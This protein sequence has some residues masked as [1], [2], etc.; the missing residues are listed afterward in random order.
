MCPCCRFPFCC[1]SSAERGVTGVPCARMHASH[2]WTRRRLGNQA[3]GIMGGERLARHGEW[4][5]RAGA[6]GGRGRFLPCGARGL[7]G[8]RAG[9]AEP[10]TPP[11]PGRAPLI[12]SGGVASPSFFLLPPSLASVRARAPQVAAD[13]IPAATGVDACS[14]YIYPAMAPH[15]STTSR[16]EPSFFLNPTP[17]TNAGSS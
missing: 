7:L 14:G 17:S 10:C 6:C 12:P 8:P 1:C 11:R 9:R 4:P 16:A 3:G 13:W 5:A 15:H 2:V